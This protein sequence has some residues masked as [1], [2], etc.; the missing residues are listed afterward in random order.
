[1][2]TL[3]SNRGPFLL[4]SYGFRGLEDLAVTAAAVR[5]AGDRRGGE[6]VEGRHVVIAELP[7]EE[8]DVFNQVGLL[9]EYNAATVMPSSLYGCSTVRGVSKHRA[10]AGRYFIVRMDAVVVIKPSNTLL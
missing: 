10:Q 3:V 7:I 4:A 1:M 5:I 6:G 8:V 9:C 2:P